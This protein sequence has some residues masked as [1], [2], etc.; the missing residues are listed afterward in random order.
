MYGLLFLLLKHAIE[1]L[2]KDD[3]LSLLTDNLI[4]KHRTALKQEVY[5]RLM[6]NIFHAEAKTMG[7]EIYPFIDKPLIRGRI[8]CECQ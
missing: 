7:F 5:Y 4:I 8:V 1:F 3:I 2:G 6:I